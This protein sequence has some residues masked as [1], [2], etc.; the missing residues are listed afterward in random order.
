MIRLRAEAPSTSRSPPPHIILSHTIADTPP[1]GTPPSRTPPL[2]PIPLPAS[3]LSLLLP[4]AD[5]RADRPEVCLLPRKRLC[6]AF[7]PRYEVGESSSAADARLTRGFRADYCFVATV[8]KEVRHDLERDVGYGITDTWD[9]MLVDMPG[10]L[11]TDDTELG[12][13]MTEFTT[14]VRQDTDEIYTRLDDEQTERQLMAGRL[15]MLYRDRR[16]HARTALLMEREARMS[17]EDWGRSI[18]ASDLA[19]SEGMSLCTTVLGQ[20]AV[21]T[22]FQA[23]DHRRQAVITELLAADRGRQAQFIEAL[24]LLKR[25]QTQMTEFESQQGPAKGP[26]QPDAPEEAGSSS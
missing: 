8:D 13:R 22:E 10:A 6:F 19:H 14:R 1:S 15:N 17:R 5:H 16:A 25:L 9:E 4:S 12:R 3:S 26:T 2:L 18:D 11:A 7:G 23:V 21:I 20:Q 24:K